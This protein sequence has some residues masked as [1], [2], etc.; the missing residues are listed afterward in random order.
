MK[1]AQFSV[2]TLT[3]IADAISP[4]LL[5]DTANGRHIASAKI[6]LFEPVRATIFT[7]YELTDVVVM[8]AKVR[9]GKDGEKNVLTEEVS[10]DYSKIKQ[11]VFTSSGPVA[12]CWDREKMPDVKREVIMNSSVVS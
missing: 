9:G 12:R 1:R 3:K 8:G 4:I 2:F 11:T 5:V 6:E 7:S 10:L